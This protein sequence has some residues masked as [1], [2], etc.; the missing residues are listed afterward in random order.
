[1][2][3]PQRIDRLKTGSAKIGCLLNPNG[4]QA[5]TRLLEIRQ[6]LQQ[7]P[8]IVLHE[9]TNAES[10]KVALDELLQAQIDLL[11]IVA[12]MALRMQFLHIY[13]NILNLVMTGPF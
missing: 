1:M 13:S 12:G 9:G 10:F 5:R 2:L 7:I 8:A 4:G 11:V 3:L 6:I